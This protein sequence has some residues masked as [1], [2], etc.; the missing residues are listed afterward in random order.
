MEHTNPAFSAD[1]STWLCEQKKPE[2]IT[3][4]INIYNI[5]FNINT[6]MAVIAM[7]AAL[8]F[9]FNSS[10]GLLSRIS[11]MTFVALL[12]LTYNRRH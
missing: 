2:R 8:L 4:L 5:K 12:S 10:D 6:L 7:I 3:R 11:S 1:K 9:V